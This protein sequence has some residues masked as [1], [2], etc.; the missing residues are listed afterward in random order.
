[1]RILLS[2][3]TVGGVWDHTVA[4]A[5]ELDEAGHEVLAAVLGE[6][7][8]ERLAALPAGVQVTWR[9]YR[10][11]WMADAAEDVAAAGA[12]L[13]GLAEVWSADVAHL[14]QMAYAAAGFPCPTVVAVHSDVLSWFGETRREAAPAEWAAYARWVREGLAAADAVVAPTRYQAGLVARHYGRRVDRVI[15]N[16]VRARPAD[17]LDRAKTPLL[18]TVGRAWDA[19]KGVDVLDAALASMGD[20]APRCHLL[21][22]T[23][24]PGGQRVEPRALVAHGRVERPQVDAWMR[25]ATHYVAPSRYEP[26]GLAPLEAALHGCALVL[27]D[28]PSFRELWDGCAWFFAR[29]DADALA[30]AIREATA[31]EGRRRRMAEAARTRALRRYTAPWMASSYAALYDTLAGARLTTRHRAT[32]GRA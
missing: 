17:D 32:A 29:G 11:E 27:S 23:E 21:G 6:P 10:L 3:D 7:R 9:P 8:D 13:R 16:G 18:L 22:E 19:A 4:L 31:D 12:W 2:T 28:C 20:A 15:P 26:F 5:R 1:M 14:N 30:D 24:G 25:R